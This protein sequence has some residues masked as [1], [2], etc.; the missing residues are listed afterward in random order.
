M[1][2]SEAADEIT[3]Q[4]QARPGTRFDT[5]AI[6]ACLDHTIVKVQQQ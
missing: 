6:A 5:G 1:Q 2:V 3:L 4:L